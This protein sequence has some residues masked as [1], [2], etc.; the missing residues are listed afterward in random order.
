MG[1]V[2]AGPENGA[3]VGQDSGK[4]VRGQRQGTVLNQAAKSIA[5]SHTL[6]PELPLSGVHHTA[7]GGVEPGAIPPAGQYA[8]LL[9]HVPCI[10]MRRTILSVRLSN[11]GLIIAN[12]PLEKT[13]SCFSRSYSV[14]NASVRASWE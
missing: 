1:L 9:L 5:E 12:D 11:G 10:P 13:I 14:T 6:H 3:A 7:D 4:D 8:D 2:P